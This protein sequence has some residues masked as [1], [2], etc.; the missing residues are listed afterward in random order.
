MIQGVDSLPSPTLRLCALAAL[1]GCSTGAETAG[2]FSLP[3]GFEI[4]EYA[5]QDLAADIYTLTLSPRG[6]VTVAG[7]GYI[8]VLKDDDGDGIADRAVEFAD[9]PRD[10]AMG[11]WW[12][13]DE[14]LAVGDGGIQRFLDANEDDVA[15]GPPLRMRALKTGGEHDSH[16]IRRGPDGWHYLLCGNE[17]RV[18]SSSAELPSSPVKDPV[19][20]ALL[21]F[22]P[23]F[24]RSEIV[25]DGFRNAY[26]FDFNPD[27]EIFVYDS[28]N[29]RDVSLPFYE[30][31]RLYH[32]TPGFHYGWENPQL[33]RTWRMP[34]YFFDVDRPIATLGR[35]SPTGVVYHPGLA[36]SNG[37]RGGL[38]LADWTFGRIYFTPLT[39]EGATY[40]ATPEVFLQSLGE[41]GFA[42]TDLAV[43]PGTGEIYISIGGRGTRGA[44]YRV[45]GPMSP[46]PT[47]PDSS[48]HA[49]GN[50]REN[51]TALA[52]LRRAGDSEPDADRH[53]AIRANWGS[54]NRKIRQLSAK[55][56]GDLGRP[57]SLRLA[58]D[59]ADATQGLTL[60]WGLAESAP[61]VAVGFLIQVLESPEAS[62]GTLVDAVRLIQ[63]LLG[64]LMAPEAMSTIWEGYSRR[65]P[66]KLGIE[67]ESALLDALESH[68]PS[69][70]HDL[71]FEIART[72]AQVESPAPE[73]LSKTLGQ[74]GES[75]APSDD[76][77][78]LAVVGRLTAKRSPAQTEKIA[79]A[80]LALDGKVIQRGWNRERHWP[81]RLGEMYR[82]LSKKDPN[83]DEAILSHPLFGAEDHLAFIN[84]K[85]FPKEK[86]AR[87]FIE[88][89]HTGKFE[90]TASTAPLLEH[91]PL[92]EGKPLARELWDS[93]PLRDAL[94]HVMASHPE[95]TDRD[96]L[97]H[98]L[99]SFQPEVVQISLDA[100]RSLKPPSGAEE[101]IA[102]LEAFRNWESNAPDEQPSSPFDDY[103]RT[104]SGLESEGRTLADW[105]GAIG[106]ADPG[107]VRLWEERRSASVGD[108]KERI[109][110]IDWEAGRV[111]E[112]GEVYDRVG[113]T[114]CH[115][116]RRTLGPDLAGVGRRFGRED[117]LVAL[118]D[119][120]RDIPSQYRTK[121]IET[122]D[123]E[124]YQGLVVYEAVDSLILQNG[125][126]STYRI[127]GE[128][129]V[130]EH[131]SKLSIMP[132]GLLDPLTDREIADLV[133]YLQSLE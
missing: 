79:A 109:A 45:T 7:R 125:P 81:W 84:T 26:D 50:L 28:D 118:I 53:A 54:P 32:V 72:L 82:A 62:A 130:S 122:E 102:V 86:A 21:R 41:T 3:P 73:H 88:L 127:D 124:I 1:V 90:W 49:G 29:E 123:G 33:A 22:T 119:P 98:R 51:L 128:K 129:I 10:G 13:G 83:L 24:S 101:W 115:T 18:V 120:S 116:G 114:S 42:P 35:G 44:V 20:G 56:I 99:A 58:M 106:K 78:Y 121:V 11:L 74:I 19:A 66:S 16:A 60:A 126:D 34:P 111:D 75:T 17:S 113:C 46:L 108:W 85:D 68:F 6:D 70:S 69:G 91:L 31:T 36:T 117:L 48:T 63:V 27:G 14:L 25:A 96:K 89:Q 92:D 76:I 4:V 15:D 57:S 77:H 133:A 40:S 110:G 80:M 71:D 30:P 2:D 103:L 104:V 9:S 93:P 52:D 8:R 112:G 67:A 47:T 12:E 61:E 59:A 97:F 38:L 64:D 43:H 55:L 23:D 131:P 107:I 95:E 87:R 37:R 39:P 65:G 94:V 132:S 100:L 105:V 5:A